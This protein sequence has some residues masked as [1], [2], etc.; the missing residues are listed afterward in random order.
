MNYAIFR[1]NTAKKRSQTQTMEQKAQKSLLSEVGQLVT[2]V[3]LISILVF[4]SLGSVL[5]GL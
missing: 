4:N 3:I 2:R 1:E 5:H